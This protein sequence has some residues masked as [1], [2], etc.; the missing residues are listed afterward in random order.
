[1]SAWWSGDHRD[2]TPARVLVTVLLGASLAAAATFGVAWAAGFRDVWQVFSRLDWR[3]LPLVAG[4][5][6]ISHVGYVIA[7]RGIIA[8]LAPQPVPGPRIGA[9]VLAG[10][11]PLSPRS[12]F[13]LDSGLWRDAGL[14]A[15][16]SSSLVLLLAL[17]EYAVLAPATFGAAI[18][19]FVEGYRAQSGLLPSWVLGVP[20]GAAVTI[21]LVT[22]RHRLPD[23]RGVR[24]LK[25]GLEAAASVWRLLRT[26]AGLIAAGGMALYWAS[27]I[28]ALGV[29][30]V[31]VHRGRTPIAVLI[32]GYA[33]GYALT[34]RSLPLAGAGAVEALLPFAISWVS[35]PLRTAV[36]AVF[37][38]RLINLWLPLVP[39]AV[40]LRTFRRR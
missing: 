35:R 30:L 7:Y 8:D 22:V 27:D 10:F 16:Q 3:W 28:A 23:W 31:I 5:V 37:V 13:T 33:T 19:L 25:R 36:V 20:I 18:V 14:E 26:R 9:A 21:P 1:L 4:L 39:S 12:G 29:C 32:V 38:Y 6:A 11:G 24:M 15:G 34:R 17:L 40:A 2:I